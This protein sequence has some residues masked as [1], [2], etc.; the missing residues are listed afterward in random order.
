MFALAVAVADFGKLVTVRVESA[1]QSSPL[2]LT[3]RDADPDLG[4]RAAN[5]LGAAL[6]KWD[7]ARAKQNLQVVIDRL[8]SQV[9]SFDDEIASLV[10]QNA[11]DA[12]TGQ[13]DGLRS[14]RADRSMQLNAVR[15]LSASAVGL[16]E[17][18]EPAMPALSPSRPQPARNAALAF[19]LGIF[20]VYGLVLLRDSLDTCFRGAEE[21]K[22][23]VALG[24]AE[25]FAR[26][27][28]HTLLIDADLRK[29]QASDRL[30]LT[31]A[32]MAVDGSA[33]LRAYLEDPKR[34]EEPMTVQVDG[35]SFDVVPTFEPAPAPTELLS[36]S[37][38][39]VWNSP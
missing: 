7:E 13:I 36:R 22:T 32:R 14:L 5:A 15:A 30:G 23:T 29:P 24:L 31:P 39:P 35:A 37:F 34:G 8:Q 16:L 4:A 26:N 3:V 2:R 21:G 38:A 11:G 6:L 28:Y 20:L 27:D 25:T 10:A 33:T 9:V 12:L 19:V 17:V 18:L 1:Q